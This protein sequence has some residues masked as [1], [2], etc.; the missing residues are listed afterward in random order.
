MIRVFFGEDAFRSRA[1]YRTAQEA[2][3]LAAGTPVT[4]LR[5]DAL[6][7]RAFQDAAEGQS[8]FGITPPLA[9]ERLTAWTG[10]AAES[11][12][13][14][15]ERLPRERTLLVWEEGVPAMAGRVWR[16]LRDR[17]DAVE[18]CSPL[19]EAEVLG[20]IAARCV[21]SGLT[22]DTT[23]V[24]ALLAL[25]GNDL[26]ALASEIEKLALA[27]RTG[28]LT[29]EDVQAWTSV[30]AEADAFGVVRAFARGDGRAALRLLAE[31]RK[32]GEDP[33]R[34]LFLI[35]RELRRLLRVRDG[36]DRGERLTEWSL[37]RE[38]RIPR[39]AAD[40]LLR[41]AHA[42]STPVMRGMVDRCVVAYYHLNSGRAE[43]GEV[44]E[45]LALHSLRAL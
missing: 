26:F 4:I 11:V 39:A 20:W 12:V 6:T 25:F 30:R 40:T 29:A 32:A 27:S 15:L 19:G 24:R 3:R 18:E 45:Q 37:A 43:A 16:A 7:P 1:A 13:R 28:R 21:E 41:S 35:V 38:F 33:R 10:D 8:L 17:A 34:L 44:L 5:G 36:L 22:P 42:T 31:Y 2:A 9:V 23:A 14:T